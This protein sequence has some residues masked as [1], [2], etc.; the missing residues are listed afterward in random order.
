M[1]ELVLV[2]RGMPLTQVNPYRDGAGHLDPVLGAFQGRRLTPAG[3][4]TT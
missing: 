3:Q 1:D 4:T 2:A